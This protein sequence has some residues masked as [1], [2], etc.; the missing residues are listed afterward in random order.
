MFLALHYFSHYPP[1]TLKAMHI[2]EHLAKLSLHMKEL[3]NRLHTAYIFPNHSP[4]L[5]DPC[6]VTAD[7]F[8]FS[9]AVLFGCAALPAISFSLLF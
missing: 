3:R 5:I 7:K 1:Q 2:K 8:V 6:K 4:F 9:K